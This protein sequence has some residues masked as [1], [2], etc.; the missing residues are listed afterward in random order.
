MNVFEINPK[1]HAYVKWLG[2]R[3]VPLFCIDNIFA[4]PNGVRQF[5]F[6]REFPSSQAYYP[7]RHQPLSSS[8]PGVASFCGFIA[9]LLSRATR[10]KISPGSIAS[11][12]SI[13]TTPE[14][15]LLGTQGQPH[16]DGTP[17]LGVIY[18]N[19]GDYGGT[20][21]FRNRTTKSMRVQTP[22]EKAHYEAITQDKHEAAR[23]TK[24]ITDSDQDWEK[25]DLVDGL[26]NRLVIWPG[27]VFHSIEVKVPPEKG[28]FSE[29][30]LTQRVIVNQLA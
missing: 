19:D 12:F 16:I 11:D 3:E 22:V 29:K 17:M 23:P 5:A 20:I 10:K 6:Q 30:R 26:K 1:H 13:L 4:N 15:K 9:D 18:L 27:N 21:F 7:G 25:V 14:G 28:A 2:N 24:Y 8:E